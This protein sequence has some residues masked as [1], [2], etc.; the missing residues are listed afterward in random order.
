[1]WVEES[2]NSFTYSSVFHL[3]WV[4]CS[5]VDLVWVDGDPGP[6]SPAKP[7]WT[8]DS[9]TVSGRQLSC[10]TTEEM[11]PVY[12][13]IHWGHRHD[14][15]TISVCMFLWFW[16]PGY[17][18]R[19]FRKGE[20]KESKNLYVAIFEDVRHLADSPYLILY[21]LICFRS[22]P[23]PRDDAR[24][25]WTYFKLNYRHSFYLKT[26]WENWAPKCSS[27]VCLDKGHSCFPA[28]KRPVRKGKKC[29]LYFQE[30]FTA[31]VAFLMPVS[32]QGNSVGQAYS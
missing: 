24:N 14:L 18:A 23:Q 2:E 30:D 17:Q 26:P 6:L 22:I 1:M 13:E 12:I 11:A 9:F 32:C 25:T 16:R 8:H 4:P 5:L 15:V 28:A 3:N 20:I 19:C 27:W 31:R 21:Y 10:R 7:P 29:L